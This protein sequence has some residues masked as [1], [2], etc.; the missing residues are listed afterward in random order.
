VQLKPNAGQCRAAARRGSRSASLNVA[1][2][3][4]RLQKSA[5]DSASRYAAVV[6]DSESQEKNTSPIEATPSAIAD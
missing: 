6:G 3:S 2:S 1:I 5:A 4:T